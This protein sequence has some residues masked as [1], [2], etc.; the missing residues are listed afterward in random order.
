MPEGMEYLQ[1]AFNFLRDGGFLLPTTPNVRTLAAM[2]NHLRRPWS[3]QPL[4]NVLTPRQLKREGPRLVHHSGSDDDYPWLWREGTIRDRQ[5]LQAWP[6]SCKS[7]VKASIRRRESPYRLRIAYLRV[8]EKSPL[9][10]AEP[11]G[12][13]KLR[14][15]CE[16][17]DWLAIMRQE[18]RFGE[19]IIE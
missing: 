8:G 11:I 4:E 6:H 9:K 1:I 12:G 18:E 13:C 16:C 17:G 7:E 5:F 19:P 15:Q 2:Q 3:D 14:Q 10:N